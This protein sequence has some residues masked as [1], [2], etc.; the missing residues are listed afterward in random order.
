MRKDWIKIKN[1][2]ITHDISLKKIAKKF[3]VSI[4]AV[5]KHCSEENWVKSKK[6]KHAEIDQKVY[7]KIEK[8]EI[9][10]KVAANELHTEL[11]GKGLKLADM[12]LD[13]YLEELQSG[14]KIKK[15]TAYNLD[16]I[17]KTIAN[18]Q[19]GQ[20][21]S[22]NINNEIITDDDMPEIHIIKGLDIE[23]I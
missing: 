19:K 14:K 1:Y 9:D 3:K 22:L 18:A 15:A 7:Q 16:F 11:Y 2:Y 5:K 20:R 17:V 12:L 23:E 4:T 21:M 6:E 13:M 10:K 8:C